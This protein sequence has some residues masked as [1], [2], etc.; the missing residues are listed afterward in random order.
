MQGGEQDSV[1]VHRGP[2]DGDV[3]AAGECGHCL[4]ADR[5]AC[6]EASALGF[7]W[8]SDAREPDGLS[9]LSGLRLNLRIIP[10]ARALGY[11]LSL[12]WSWSFDVNGDR[13]HAGGDWGEDVGG[14]WRDLVRHGAVHDLKGCNING[15][16]CQRER[17][18]GMRTG[19]RREKRLG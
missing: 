11:R 19:C 2:A 7:A 4:W 1:F 18:F 3:E 15:W 16:R 12:L 17:S 6:G 13:E 8:T 10:R 5:I 9:S 14:L